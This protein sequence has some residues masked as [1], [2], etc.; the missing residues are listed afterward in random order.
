MEKT[1]HAST[2]SSASEPQ[3]ISGP[4]TSQD[5]TPA[6]DLIDYAKSYARQKPEVAALWCFGAGFVL[7]WKIKP[8]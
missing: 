1:Q 5:L 2:P 4:T 6:N 7:G 8:W 3:R